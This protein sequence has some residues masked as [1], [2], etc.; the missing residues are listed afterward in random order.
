MKNQIQKVKGGYTLVEILF[1]IALFSVLTLAIINSFVTMTKAFKEISIQSDLV[2]SSLAIER[3]SREIRQAYGINSI[4]TSDLKLNTKDELD[5]NETVRFLLSGSDIQLFENDVLTGNL[6]TP[7]IQVVNLSFTQIT[8]VN[9]NAIKISLSVK[10]GRDM[11]NRVENFY[12]T[13]LL[14]GDYGS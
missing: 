6:N 7:N 2:Q 13:V 4:T 14:R 5:N 9:G 11:T 3:M 1:Y 10:S 12:N 8:T